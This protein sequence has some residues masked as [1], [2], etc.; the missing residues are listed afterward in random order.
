MPLNAKESLQQFNH[1]TP[2][3]PQYQPYL[4]PDRSYGADTQKMK[5]IDMSPALTTD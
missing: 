2:K 1:K 3:K 4:A 5:L